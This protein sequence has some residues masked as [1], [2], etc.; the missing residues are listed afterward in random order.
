M[1]QAQK[2]LIIG[3]L[4]LV[5]WGMLYGLFYA[6]TVEHPRLESMGATLAQAFTHAAERNLPQANT[7]LDAHA[8][9]QYQYVREVDVHSHWSGLG[10]LLVIL[11]LAFDRAALRR[12]T[13]T[14]IASMLVAGSAIFPLGVFLQK[15][16]SGPVPVIIAAAAAA[17]LTLSLTLAAIAFARSETA[18][19]APE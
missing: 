18:A 5:V 12:G 3:G 4:A 17:L 10:M 7:A 15:F 1:N 8:T 2:V 14:L 13:G 11:G 6:L 16:N 19:N 9:A